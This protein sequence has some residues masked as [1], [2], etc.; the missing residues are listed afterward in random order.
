MGDTRSLDDGSYD[1]D[2]GT[3]HHHN[4]DDMLEYGQR[5]TVL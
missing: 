4:N 5:Q 2:R 3:G 1:H